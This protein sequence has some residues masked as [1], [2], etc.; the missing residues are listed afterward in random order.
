MKVISKVLLS[1]MLLSQV[2]AFAGT[3]EATNGWFVTTSPLQIGKTRVPGNTMI[4]VY[5]E[6]GQ[7]VVGFSAYSKEVGSE[8]SPGEQDL[9]QIQAVFQDHIGL[10]SFTWSTPYGCPRCPPD[11]DHLPS[12]IKI[13]SEEGRLH[14]TCKQ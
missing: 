12:Y 10:Q 11:W 4:G 7:I 2:K 6:S 9:Y 1:L 14:L 5:D 3:C 8:P 13:T